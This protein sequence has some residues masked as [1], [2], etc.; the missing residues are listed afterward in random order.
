MAVQLQVKQAEI[1]LKYVAQRQ[2]ER[3]A[4]GWVIHA[5]EASVNEKPTETSEGASVEVDG[6]R[7]GL[8][9]RFDRIDH[10][11]DT[12]R[13]AILDY[14]THGHKPEK[15]HLQ[16]TDDG[17]KWV[18]LQLPLY[19]LMIPFLGIDADPVDVQL[20]YFNV[21]EK[22]E[23]TRINVVDFSEPM[24]QRADD[25]I[26]DCIRNIWAGKFDP[27]DD[28][29]Q[30]DDYEMILQTRVPQRLL[31]YAVLFGEAEGELA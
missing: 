22:D 2:A 11:P 31:N 24:M 1:R 27:T 5:A 18:D 30:Y 8:R 28:R 21:A 9:G 19:R 26:H 7:M 17:P 14:K 13:W 3:I 23:D 10:H 29:V 12:N 25:L 16:Y 20:G 6:K 4:D 15:K